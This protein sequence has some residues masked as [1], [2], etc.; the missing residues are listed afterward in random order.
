MLCC[1]GSCHRGYFENCFCWCCSVLMS[2]IDIAVIYYNIIIY[3]PSGAYDVVFDANVF[4]FVQ[5]LLL[6]YICLVYFITAAN[7]CNIIFIL[8]V[9]LNFSVMYSMWI[10][11]LINVLVLCPVSVSAYISCIH[12]CIRTACD[13][14]Y[15]LI[16]AVSRQPDISFF[17]QTCCL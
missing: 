17:L 6:Q 1:N 5:Q 12:T 7:A 9:L 15:Q 8:T 10:S 2:R 14:K 16:V 13:T 11:T 4:V 3:C